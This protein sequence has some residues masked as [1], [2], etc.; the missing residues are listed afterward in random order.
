MNRLPD[1]SNL[2]HLKKQAKDLLRLYRNRDAQAIARFRD[3]LP[4]AAGRSDDQIASL[5]LRLHDAQSC[6]ARDYGF[7]SWA[8]LRRYVEA[9]SA[10]SGDHAARVLHW[11]K[12]VYSGDVNGTAE[13]ANPRVAV[14][15][16]AESPDLAAGSP[17]LAC[18]IGDEDALR[19]ATQ[20]DPAW[21]DRPGGPLKLPP[22]AAITHSSL[23]QVPEF[24]E[25]LHRGAR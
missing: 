16:L 22:L 2:D 24:R 3:A 18:A 8:D 1:R 19:Q 11:L 15:M 23:L 7:A 4:A 17:Y 9:Q 21:V 6:V 10:S 20:A 5:K 12:L 25:R 13:R 14:R